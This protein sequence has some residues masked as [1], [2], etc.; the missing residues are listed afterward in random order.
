MAIDLSKLNR[1]SQA[2]EKGETEAFA[3]RKGGFVGLSHIKL[4]GDVQLNVGYMTLDGD[5]ERKVLKVG[6]KVQYADGKAVTVT[7]VRIKV[8]NAGSPGG[9]TLLSG[10]YPLAFR[11]A[12]AA[13][14][15]D[16]DVFQAALNKAAEGIS[17]LSLTPYFDAD[18]S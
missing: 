9:A 6:G 16:P 10:K 17:A 1:V 14:M 15:L 12:Q 4:P 2:S 7:P 11:F 8:T 5:P 18:N 3:Y 13:C